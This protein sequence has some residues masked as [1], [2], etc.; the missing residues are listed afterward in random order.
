MSQVITAIYEDGIL[1]PLQKLDLAS[2]Q[3]VRLIILPHKKAEAKV[4]KT[5]PLYGLFPELAAITAADIEEAE[6][7]WEKGAVSGFLERI[8]RI[9]LDCDQPIR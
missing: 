2:P 9:P 4:S 5:R 8:E 3:V 6:Q 7:I 1:R